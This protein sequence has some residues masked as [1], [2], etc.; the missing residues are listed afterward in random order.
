M[1][2]SGLAGDVLYG[3]QGWAA[4]GYGLVEWDAKSVRVDGGGEGCGDAGAA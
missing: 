4:V 2:E 1:Q 3:V